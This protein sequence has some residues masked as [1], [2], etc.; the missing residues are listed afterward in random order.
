MKMCTRWPLKATWLYVDYTKFA[1]FWA[2]SDEHLHTNVISQ[3]DSLCLSH[4]ITI[5]ELL[6][7]AF[8]YSK[9]THD[10]F[11]SNATKP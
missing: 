10:A 4:T 1:F 8:A 9:R 2:I 6:M 7:L 11:F 3:C 5:A